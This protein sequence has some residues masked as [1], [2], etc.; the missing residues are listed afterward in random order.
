MVIL[1]LACLRGDLNQGEGAFA[2][3]LQ[4]TLFE[5][6]VFEE[7]DDRQLATAQ[8]L[9]YRKGGSLPFDEEGNLKL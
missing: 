6:R 8:A 5:V 4:Q 1:F 7:A 2:V 9:A 3:L